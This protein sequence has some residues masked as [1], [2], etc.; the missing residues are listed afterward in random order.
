[1]V[2]VLPSTTT[3]LNLMQRFNNWSAA[4][5]NVWKWPHKHVDMTDGVM[6]V[7]P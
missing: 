7:A 2:K 4:F 3:K 6:L 1:M 5:V